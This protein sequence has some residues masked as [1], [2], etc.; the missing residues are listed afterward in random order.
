VTAVR[1]LEVITGQGG[2]AS[3]LG[4]SM[5]LIAVVSDVARQNGLSPQQVFYAAAT[6]APTD[7]EH[8]Q[9]DSAIRARSCREGVA[10]TPGT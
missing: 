4:I 7:C 1:R 6:S 8:G 3:F 10:T 9:Q 2:G 5:S